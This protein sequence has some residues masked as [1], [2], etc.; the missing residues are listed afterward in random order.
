VYGNTFPAHHTCVLQPHITIHGDSL[1]FVS[2]PDVS[3]CTNGYFEV[4]SRT[5][6]SAR[7]SVVANQTRLCNDDIGRDSA[8]L[9]V[10]NV[11]ITVFAALRVVPETLRLIPGSIFQVGQK[12]Y[13]CVSYT[14][15]DVDIC[16][17]LIPH[18]IFLEPYCFFFFVFF[19]VFL[20]FVFFPKLFA[21]DSRVWRA[22][23]NSD[24]FELC[25]GASSHCVRRP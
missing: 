21:T 3:I 4:Y 23:R 6:G 14:S 25:V 2:D 18:C 1:A 10:A 8:E 24:S 12:Y 22:T 19:F 16:D 11:D 20:C 13:N 17:W 15:F 5:I 7:V 9:L